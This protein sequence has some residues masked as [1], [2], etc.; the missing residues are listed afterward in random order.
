MNENMKIENAGALVSLQ[1][2]ALPLPVLPPVPVCPACPCHR[3]PNNFVYK[4]LT[5]GTI[6]RSTPDLSSAIHSSAIMNN[7][8][9]RCILLRNSDSPNPVVW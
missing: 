3:C 9:L 7:K 5:A 6:W 1:Q 4:S 2:A 8:P